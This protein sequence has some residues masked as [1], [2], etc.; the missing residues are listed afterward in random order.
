MFLCKWSALMICQLVR[1]QGW[2][3][4]LL[5]Y[6]SLSIPQYPVVFVLQNC[7]LWYSACIYYIII[8]FGLVFSLYSYDIIFF[9]FW[10][11]PVLLDI[12]IST[13]FGWLWIPFVWSIIFYPFIFSLYVFARE[14][15]FVQAANCWIFLKV[16]SANPCL[17]TKELK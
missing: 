12:F 14:V 17:L 9:V 4:S 16:W 2:S 11:L 15:S 1:M 7:V 6:W 8:Y 10:F 5:L 13:F 3:N